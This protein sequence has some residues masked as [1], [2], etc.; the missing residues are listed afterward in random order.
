VGEA[1]GVGLMGALEMVAD[2]ETKAPYPASLEV[3]ERVAR[4]AMKNGLIC[5]PL[6]P[7]VVLAP[8]FIIT[9]EQVDELFRLLRRTLD[10]VYATLPGK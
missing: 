3:S 5:R 6:G 9:K 2:K 7:A 4:Q 8:P 1:R 10:E